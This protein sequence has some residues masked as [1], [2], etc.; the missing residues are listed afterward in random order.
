MGIFDTAK[1]VATER[2]YTF[3]DI[4]HGIEHPHAIVSE[5]NQQYNHW[6]AG[7]PYNPKGIDV[8]EEDWDNF[9]ILDA[10]RYDEF[11]HR[12]SLPGTTEYRISRGS[13]SPEFVRGNFG[14]K[15]LHDVVYVTANNWYA[16]TK[17]DIDAEIYALDTVD[18]DLFDGRTS[19]PETVAAAARDAAETYPD[20]RLVIHFMQPHWPYLGPTGE[21]FENAPFHEVMRETDATHADVMQAYREN[22]DIVLGEVE[23]LLDDLQGKTVVSADHGELLGDRERPIPIKTYRHPEGVYVDGLVKVP[24]H[25]YQ[26]GERKEI[27]AEQPAEDDDDIDIEAVEQHLADLGYRV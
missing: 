7:Q 12:S 20:K 2:K 10:C 9:V 6:R 18:R 3:D 27:V 14:G 19:H 8:F 21:K 13:T 11:A 26:N 1:R 17:D 16:K 22:V 25:V 4:V 24:W 15:R 5:I 23:P